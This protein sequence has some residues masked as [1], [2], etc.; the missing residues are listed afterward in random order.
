MFDIFVIE[1]NGEY[2]Y[3][4]R[5]GGTGFDVADK[6]QLFR[7]VKN[8]NAT[9]RRMVRDIEQRLEQEFIAGRANAS[10]N[11]GAERKLICWKNARVMK[12]TVSGMLPG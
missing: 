1:S 12:L 10:Y 3:G 9:I 5:T 11:E 7:N 6:A 4:S 2:Y 8:A